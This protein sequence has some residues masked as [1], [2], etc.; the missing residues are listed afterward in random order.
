VNDRH[1][2]HRHAAKLLQ[3]ALEVSPV[4]VLMGARQTGKSTLVQSEPFLTGEQRAGASGDRLY[5]SLDDLAARERAREAP[6]DFVRSAPRMTIDEVQRH[7]DL[8][9]AIKQAVDQDRPRRPGR[10]VLTGSANLL[11]LERISETLAGRATYVTLWPLTRRERLGLGRVGLWEE[12]ITT[13]VDDWP[14]LVRGQED[15]PGDWRREARLGGYPTPSVEL[16][17]DEARTLWFDGYVRTYLERDLQ[18]LAAIDNLLDFRRLMRAA[19]HRLGNLLNQAELGRDTRISRPTVHRYLNLLETSYQLVRLEPYAV[20]RTKRLIKSP[21]LFW[22]DTG[23]AFHLGGDT[24]PTGAHLEN[25][26]LTD[27]LA[28]RH[29]RVPRPEVLYWRTAGGI[30]VD[31]VIEHRD[32]LVPIEVKAGSRPGLGDLRGLQTFRDEYPDLFQG[33]LLLHTGDETQWLSDRILAVPWHR[34]V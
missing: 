18:D 12:L 9:L 23:L 19:S 5:V 11:L 32:G 31:F 8:I 6:E 33:G 1:Y 21:K 25:L 20:N 13:P 16:T 28:W 15:L 2:L 34:V 22:S 7:P 14:E 30:E 24:Q 17:S 4:V 10:F 29:A 3:Q 27:L 26:V